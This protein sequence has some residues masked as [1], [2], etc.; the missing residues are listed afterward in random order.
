M[1]AA[2]LEKDQERENNTKRP[3]VDLKREVIR[4]APWCKKY[5][6]HCPYL[7]AAALQLVIGVPSTA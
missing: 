1:P 6:T 5:G 4:R 7:E 2:A 3:C